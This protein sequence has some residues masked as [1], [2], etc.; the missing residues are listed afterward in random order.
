MQGNWPFLFLCGNQRS[1]G[2]RVERQEGNRKFQAS[3]G[4]FPP[5]SSGTDKLIGRECFLK[6][7]LAVQEKRLGLPGPNRDGES[8]DFVGGISTAGQLACRGKPHRNA[9]LLWDSHDIASMML[10]HGSDIITLP[11][12]CGQNSVVNWATKS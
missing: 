11:R 6:K 2:K 3:F 9:S 7:I 12:L 8:P 5:N 4:A 1:Q 10:S